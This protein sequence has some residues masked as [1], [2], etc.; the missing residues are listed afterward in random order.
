V[1]QVMGEGLNILI[2]TNLKYIDFFYFNNVTNWFNK[3]EKWFLKYIR[4][5]TED[6]VYKMAESDYF[7]NDVKHNENLKIVS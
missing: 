6:N 5:T 3:T 2:E 4:M 1:P 7:K